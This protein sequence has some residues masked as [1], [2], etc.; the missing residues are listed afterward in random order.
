[1]VRTLP[2]SLKTCATLLCCRGLYCS[3]GLRS[4]VVT[5]VILLCDKVESWSAEHQVFAVGDVVLRFGEI[6]NGVPNLAPARGQAREVRAIGAV[7][8]FVACQDGVDEIVEFGIARVAGRAM[9]RPRDIADMD[10]A[11]GWL[12]W[13]EDVRVRSII[14]ARAA[15]APREEIFGTNANRPNVGVYL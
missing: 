3:H 14:L 7:H 9:D 10:E 11:L 5:Y 13:I 1:M 2:A 4:L 12:L 8:F 15:G 6:D